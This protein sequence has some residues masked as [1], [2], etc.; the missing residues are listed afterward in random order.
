LLKLDNSD[1]TGNILFE[2]HRATITVKLGVILNRSREYVGIG[3]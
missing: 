1:F 3:G 2:G